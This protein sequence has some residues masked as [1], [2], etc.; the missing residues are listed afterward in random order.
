MCVRLKCSTEDWKT[1]TE[2]CAIV[3]TCVL[4]SLTDR[5]LCNHVKCFGFSVFSSLFF[6]FVCWYLQQKWHLMSAPERSVADCNYLF[7]ITL[8][9]VAGVPHSHCFSLLS[10]ILDNDR[11]RKKRGP[12]WPL[13]RAAK[14]STLPNYS[15]GTALPPIWPEHQSARKAL[16]VRPVTWH[17]PPHHCVPR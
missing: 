4:F 15:P 8:G 9:T 12:F 13:D 17:P 11:C 5:D 1:I 2:L 10:V 6:P 3:S 7:I 16:R 14:L